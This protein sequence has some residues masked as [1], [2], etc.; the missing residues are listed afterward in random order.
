[1]VACGEGISAA[2]HGRSRRMRAIGTAVAGL[3][4]DPYPPGGFY[5]GREA[6]TAAIITVFGSA[7]IGWCA[8][9]RMT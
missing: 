1:M 9:L 5:R 4:E 2:L 3:A 6:S 7:L 8:S